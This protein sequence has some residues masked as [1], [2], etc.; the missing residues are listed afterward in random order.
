MK[1]VKVINKLTIVTRYFVIMII[2]II[3]YTDI[4]QLLDEVEQSIVICRWQEDQLFTDA[5]GGDKLLIC[6][7]LTNHNI[8]QEPSAVIVL[9]F[10]YKVCHETL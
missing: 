6:K 3:R 4:Y 1:F 8:L 5:E 7:L 10:I 9:S 2:I